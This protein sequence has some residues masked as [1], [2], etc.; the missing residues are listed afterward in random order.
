MSLLSTATETIAAARLRRAVAR[1]L[2]TLDGGPE[3][4]L[5]AEIEEWAAEHR[6]R[7]AFLAADGSQRLTYVD[8]AGRVSRWARWTILHG[9][10]RGEP[11]AVLMENRP[12]RIAAWA[13]IAVASAVAALLDP[14]LDGPA[15]AAAVASV[16]ARHLVVD[17]ALLPRFETAA[18]HL[19]TMAAVW[20]HGPHPMAYPRLD[21]ALA[22][23]SPER[24]RPA[25][26]RPIAASDDALWLAAPGAPP[27]R[28][29]HRD[30]VRRMHALAAACG[31]TRD[32]R[33][34]LPEL[35][36]DDPAAAVLPGAIATVGGVCL[37][38]PPT[39]PTAIAD[40]VAAARPTLV[41]CDD[42]TAGP[43]LSALAAAA[44]SPRL[45]LA[46]GGCQDIGAA[47][48][49]HLVLS[50]DTLATGGGTRLWS[51]ATR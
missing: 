15:L 22:D 49:R 31:A 8:F 16:G 43:L 42:R 27:R 41:T 38:R 25:D 44:A 35:A 30:L 48:A 13:G 39:A 46:V 1:R 12:E 7:P 11:I 34:F 28:F 23:L 4:T 33:L 2:A 3:T 51:A 45:V 18:P 26:R 40:D 19:T 17:A 5:R 10:D 29:G 50:G 6:D 24:L 21:E 9:V 36:T 14:A 32:D 37:L 20:V 47:R